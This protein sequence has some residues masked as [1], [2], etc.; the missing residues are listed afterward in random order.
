MRAMNTA[1]GSEIRPNRRWYHVAIAIALVGVLAGAAVGIPY[2]VAF[3]N[4]FPTLGEPFRSGQPTR[5]DLRSAGTAMIYVT[6]DTARA[7]V[8]CTSGTGAIVAP[9][10]TFTF[11]SDWQSWAAVYEVT[12]F[13]SGAYEVTCT[14]TYGDAVWFAAAEG[15]PDNAAILRKLAAALAFGLVLPCVALA[16]GGI[17]FAVTLRRRARTG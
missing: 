4:A 10:D 6:P 11:L 14:D 8:S 12:A 1:Q 9:A 15:R 16:A 2:L 7:G 17:L 13:E 5:V 3:F